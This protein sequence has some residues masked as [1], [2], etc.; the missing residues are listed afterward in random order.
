MT[1]QTFRS[2]Q[3]RIAELN[4]EKYTLQKE[5]KDTSKEV[6]DLR[7]ILHKTNRDLELLYTLAKTGI[8]ASN[9]TDD[10]KVLEI[11]SSLPVGS[12]FKDDFIITS[13]F[14]IRDESAFDGDG[15][16]EGIDIIPKNKK[17]NHAVYLVEDATITDFGVSNTAGKYI[18]AQTTTGFRLVFK[19]LSKIFY[20]NELGEVRNIPL[21]AG[22]RIALMGNTGLSFGAHLHYE[23]WYHD[24]VSKL[25]SLLDPEEIIKHKGE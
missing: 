21:K 14:G 12:P 3:L 19:H 15:F 4:A 5:L 8:K 1:I 23:I 24:P 20:Q 22:T 18:I 10:T 17:A 7:E 11:A 9:V 13:R 2:D 25:Y 16:H 6:S